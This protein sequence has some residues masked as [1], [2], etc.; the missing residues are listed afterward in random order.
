METEKEF[1]KYVDINSICLTE[2][3]GLYF[4]KYEQKVEDWW[5]EFEEIELPEFKI[6][7]AE[8]YDKKYLMQL[9]ENDNSKYFD[10][11]FITV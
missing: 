9:I 10:I 5:F 2:W 8:K 7:E 6:E 1:C 3:K 11:K 4:I